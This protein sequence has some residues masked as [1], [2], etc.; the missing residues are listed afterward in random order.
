MPEER[1]LRKVLIEKIEYIKRI[2]TLNALRTKVAGLSLLSVIF[3][4]WLPRG[5]TRKLGI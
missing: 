5:V 4:S 3:L 1:Q 2:N